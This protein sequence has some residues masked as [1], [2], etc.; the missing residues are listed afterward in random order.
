MK[1]WMTIMMAVTGMVLMSVAAYAA[2]PSFSVNLGDGGGEVSS[3]LKI[4]LLITVLSVAPALLVTMTCFTRIVVVF[5]F[6]RQAIGI[7]QAPPNQVLIGLALFL[8]I[9]IM[10]PVIKQVNDKAIVPYRENKIDHVQ[11]Y[12]QALEPIRTF[13]YSQTRESDI[14][15]MLKLSNQGKPKVF[16]DLSTSVLIPSFILSELKTSFEIGFLIY[17][18]F[19]L[20][21]MLISMVLLTMGMMMMPPVLISLPFKLMIFVLVDGW[22]LLVGSLVRSFS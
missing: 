7:H 18:P 15:L 14:A 20:I 22:D 12:E 9:F 3:A 6:L 11:A 4:V 19:V 17:L 13:M 1:R 21:D 10:S 8:T 5:S 16:A 2:G